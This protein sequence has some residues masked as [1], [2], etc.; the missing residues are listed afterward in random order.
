MDQSVADSVTST[1]GTTI[2]F[3]RTGHGPPIIL[4][5]GAFTDRTHATLRHV[6]QA[7]APWFMVV[8]YDRRGRGA[9]DN[10]QPYAL[11]REIEDLAALVAVVG[12]SA[13]VFG[14]SSGAGLVLEAAA[15][16]L[17]ITK[18]ALWEP[19]YHVDRS[20]PD[21]PLD[22][23]EQLAALVEE[24]LRGDA[25]TLFLTT[26]AQVPAIAVAEMRTQP[27]WPDM[28]AIA[29][30]LAYEAVVM[31]PGNTLQGQRFAC[32]R[33]P[34]LVLTG[35]KSPPWMVNAGEAVITTIP[36]ASHR[37]LDGQTHNVAPEALAP[38]LL[39]FFVAS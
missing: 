39:E 22:F 10:V 14:G 11:E 19:P 15:R 16:N 27:C 21:L 18:L 2:A 35:A 5:H 28:E 23:A 6:A 38:E 26:A 20:A 31:G 34:T 17:P 24:G 4:V 32:L 1:D 12:G 25:V 30:T 9:S 3:D 13:M 8:N 7:L 37:V 36:H 33:Q 29:H